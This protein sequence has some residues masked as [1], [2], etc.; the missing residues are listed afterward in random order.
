MEIGAEEPLVDTLI[1][2]VRHSINEDSVAS[3]IILI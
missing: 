3:I 2:W 1:P